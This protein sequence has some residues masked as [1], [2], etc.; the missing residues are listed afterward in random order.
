MTQFLTPL[1]AD[2]FL[3]QFCVPSAADGILARDKFYTV[4]FELSPE[5]KLLCRLIED[6][7]ICLE[8]HT[9]PGWK[10]NRNEA[11]QWI[12]DPEDW[13]VFSFVSCCELLGLDPEFMRKG[14]SKK[15]GLKF[16]RR[17]YGQAGKVR[18]GRPR[19]AV[20]GNENRDN[21]VSQAIRVGRTGAASSCQRDFDRDRG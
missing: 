20:A 4:A 1:T 10:R 8:T 17:K 6:S 12:T 9:G 16:G 2:Q 15:F 7:V 13:G 19:K 21:G 18:A 14:L 11:E 3:D 5:K